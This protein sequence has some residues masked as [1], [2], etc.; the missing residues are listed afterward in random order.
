[1]IYINILKFNPFQN[2]ICNNRKRIKRAYKKWI[3]DVF[4]MY[5]F[6]KIFANRV[7]CLKCI[8]HR[9][10]NECRV[11]I[12]ISPTGE[13]IEKVNDLTDAVSQID[14]KVTRGKGNFKWKPEI[15]VQ[16]T[17]QI[18]G[19]KLRNISK[20]AASNLPSMTPLRR[21]VRKAGQDLR[22]SLRC[23]QNPK[24]Q[25]IMNCF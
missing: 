25:L 7:S 1:M 22:M 12:K 13:F 14:V 10:N 3:E 23:L 9:K 8:L 18:L 19:I 24:L 21:N 15:T 2:W 20:G 5:V 11:T 17:Q 16:K 4:K 6:K